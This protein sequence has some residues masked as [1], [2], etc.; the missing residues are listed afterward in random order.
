MG[1]VL[2]IWG[3]IEMYNNYSDEQ[4]LRQLN[5]IIEEKEAFN[6]ILKK[7]IISKD[8]VV[9]FNK[10]LKNE[11]KDIFQKSKDRKKKSKSNKYD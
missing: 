11:F 1:G 9:D 4:D 2:A 5:Q 6:K 3:L 10:Y 8:F 7:K